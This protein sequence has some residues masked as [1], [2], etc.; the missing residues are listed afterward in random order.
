[1]KWLERHGYGYSPRYPSGKLPL[2]QLKIS[3]NQKL[4]YTSLLF[5]IPPGL[6]DRL[7]FP[8]EYKKI[9][10][11]YTFLEEDVD[12]GRGLFVLMRPDGD[13]SRDL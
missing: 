13:Q 4:R 3:F 8:E 5:K 1:L 6:H 9:K 7:P 12:N 10:P 2:D 11:I